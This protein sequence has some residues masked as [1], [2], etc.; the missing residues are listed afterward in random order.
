MSAFLLIVFLL[1]GKIHAVVFILLIIS[2]Y[3]LTDYYVWTS[4]N[5]GKSFTCWPNLIVFF[6]VTKN[7]KSEIRQKQGANC[8]YIH[9]N[10]WI[11]L[12]VSKNLDSALDEFCRLCLRDHIYPW[13]STITHDDTFVYET[14]HVFRYL[15]ATII[16]RL[17]NVDI[18]AFIV[19]R[20]LP[21][22][23]QTC[24]RYIHTRDKYSAN[25]SVDFLRKMYKDDLHLAMYNRQTEIRYLKQIILDVMPIITPKFITDCKVSRHLLCELF[26]CQIL[27]DG[28]DTICQPNVLNRLFHLYFTTAIQRRQQ[29]TIISNP[30]Q[31]V[32]SS[33]EVLSQFCA[34]NRILHKNQLVLD[35]TDVMNEKELMNQFSCVLDRHGSIGLL[36]IYLSL[37]D[38][39]NEIPL[40]SDILVRKKLYQRLKHIDDLY[41]NPI[42]YNS[43][44][45][46]SNPSNDQD[47]LIDEIKHLIYYDL[48]PS[49]ADDDDDKNASNDLKKNFNVQQTFTLLSRFHCRIYELIEEKYQREFLTSDEHFL[50]ICG[51][52]MD[53][54]DYRLREKTNTNGNMNKPGSSKHYTTTSYQEMEEKDDL[55]L[56]CPD[57]TTSVC[58]STSLDERDLSTW[59][60]RI[61][62][63][64]ELRENLNTNSKYCAY[65]IEIHRF[66]STNDSPLIQ[67]D[68]KPHWIVARRYQ[69]FYLLEQKLTEFHGIFSDARLPPKRSTTIA[70]DLKFLE[71]IKHDLQHFLQHLLSK[72]TLRNSELLYN[73]LTQPDDF[74]LPNGE[75]ILAK[76]FKVVPRRLR[77]EKGQ[78]L[79]PFLL[80]LLNFIEPT[81]A[82]AT[83]PSPIFNDIIEEKLQNSM[84]GNNAN[85]TEPFFEPMTEDTANHSC[86]EIDSTYNHLVFI[87]KQVFSASPLLIHFLNLFY[88]P[89]KNTFDTFF[90]HFVETRMDEILSNDEN[91]I[92][93]IHALRD[94]IFPDVAQEKEPT[95]MVNFE[96]VIASA[97]EF[98]PN[99]IKRIIGEAN[100]QNGLQILLQHFQDPLLNKQLF[101][102]I[103]DEVLFELFPELRLQFSASRSST[104][105]TIIA[106]FFC[107]TY[108]YA[109]QQCEQSVNVARFDCYS[110]DGPTQERCEARK[111]CWRSPV[112]ET[113]MTKKYLDG[114]RDINVPYCYYPKDFP[115]YTV[116]SNEET[117][118]GQRIRIVKTQTTYMPHD[119]LDLT[120]DF[121]Y[122]TQQRFRIRIYDSVYRR[123]EV[124]L[125]VPVVEKKV[126]MTDYEV[127]FSEKPFA[128]LVTRKSTGVVL[129]DSS[130]APL[131]FA[132]QYIK[133]STR[134]SS[135]LVYGL[136]EHK[137]ALLINV[138]NEWKRLTFWARDVGPQPNTNL[139]GSHPFHINLEVNKTGQTNVHGQF[140]LNSN[141]MDVD[142]QPLPALTYTTIGGIID[143]YIFTGPT[144]QDVIEQYWDIVGKPTMP[145][146]WSIGFHLCR[147]GYLSIENLTAV[148]KRMH[149]AD[150]PYDVQWTDIDVMSSKLDFTY[151]IKNFHGLP[152]L[153]R[154]LQSNGKHY[155][156][157]IDPAISSTQPS[158]SYPPYDDGISHG[159]FITK[160]NS[161]EPIIGEVWPGATA[162]PDFTNPKTIDWWVRAAAAF[163][164]IVPFDGM[165]I[166]MNE[167]SNFVDG[168]HDGCTMNN[169]DNPPFTPHVLGGNL[170]SKTL[171]PSAQQYLSQHYNLHNMYGYFEA[172]AS[173]IALATIRKKRPF[174]LTRSSF[175]GSGKFTAHWTGDNGASFEDLYS[176]I[177]TILSFN[178]FGIT[179]VG[180]DICGFGGDTTEELC[181]KDQDPASFSWEA[182]QIM[183]QALLMRY[184]LIPFWYTLH[185]KASMRSQTIVQPLFF[186]YSNDENTYNIDQQFLIGSALL[187][188]PNLVSGSN[189]VHAYIPQDVWYEFPSGVQLRTVGQ[190]IDLN[191]PIQKINVHVRGGFIIP[192]QIPGDNLILG[193]GNPFVLLVALSQT[194]NASGSL[195]WDDGDA[196]DSIE[197]KTYNYFEFILTSSNVLTINPLVTNY[198][199]SVMALGM[200]KVLG[201]NKTVTNVNVN[202]KVYSSF[203]YN[204]PDDVL[205]VYGL[206]LNMLTSSSQTIEWITL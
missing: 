130:V 106:L 127:N 72:P 177:P 94:A 179:H 78:D 131:I 63:A 6:D 145:P 32:N 109:Q 147:W 158:G 121:I 123:Y 14:K 160:H 23:F 93:I 120:V 85:I 29:A 74:T 100:V 161:T 169:L 22:I 175:A 155:V 60:I 144:V 102:L 86:E 73:F 128:I 105:A 191:T 190:F 17:Q 38:V 56:K 39:L 91:I 141:A 7:I 201:L 53:S 165:W 79:E 13:L 96:D 36:S 118:F 134:L 58:S 42:N 111:C 64:E 16:R 69:D 182:Q 43:Y 200:V 9:K 49:I 189:T 197:T 159:V 98:I 54:P 205:L 25:D 148:M 166:D 12:M 37:S 198:R 84:Y 178:M 101:Y 199:D 174:V 75:I 137:Q 1:F 152:E 139:Y 170:T 125:Q 135:P 92:D 97:E 95:D 65:I 193:R 66:E 71:S 33:V 113:N 114:F 90:T 24:D 34:M 176:S 77:I 187:V 162:F 151:D 83:Q 8:N 183:K 138:T 61:D 18:N 21:L 122:E 181:A 196:I 62:H 3:K 30:I 124:P 157:I 150:F 188:S 108:L 153:V 129:F 27:L 143:L 142:L 171:C 82:K 20:F 26:V 194:G 59:Q 167:P 107:V 81:K 47:T 163:H 116:T 57:D 11:H 2:S 5:P 117:D 76:V 15:L 132:D 184:S 186:E 203:L 204:S 180:A 68:E 192:M 168:S 46:I 173:N 19:E 31:P 149:D 80:S 28:I 44:I 202:G 87:I 70:R 112:D 88:V 195:F 51:Q 206:D 104:M 119:I 185:H 52:R 4:N 164:E 154:T 115:T 45:V 41:L 89:L 99:M 136:G 40:A 110:D 55:H 48:E 67:H 50:Y 156:N 35:L 140:F 133:F 146:F 103:L 10:P 172:Q 126:N